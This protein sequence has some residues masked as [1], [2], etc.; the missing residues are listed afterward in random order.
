MA[1][2][3]SLPVEDTP[4]SLGIEFED[5]RHLNRFNYLKD[6]EIKSKKWGSPIF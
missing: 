3:A 2:Q 5:R 4:A 1:T 6:H